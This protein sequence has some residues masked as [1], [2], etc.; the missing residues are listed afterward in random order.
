MRILTNRVKDGYEAVEVRDGQHYW[1]GKQTT[2][3]VDY[4]FFFPVDLE[5]VKETF[6]RNGRKYDNQV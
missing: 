3:N 4:G 5:F 1:L 2:P 6:E